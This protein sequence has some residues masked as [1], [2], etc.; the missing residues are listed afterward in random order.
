M[1]LSYESHPLF[2]IG[3]DWFHVTLHPYTVFPM[4]HPS[5][6]S[7]SP[8]THDDGLWILA[9]YSKSWQQNWSEVL[10]RVYFLMILV[11][12]VTIEG[13]QGGNLSKMASI[14]AN[15]SSFFIDLLRFFGKMQHALL[16]PLT[17]CL[18]CFFKFFIERHILQTILTGLLCQVLLDHR[19]KKAS[20]F[21]KLIPNRPSSPSFSRTRHDLI[22]I[23]AINWTNIRHGAK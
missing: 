17:W 3:H 5:P 6:L 10:L 8:L 19:V 9:I 16:P 4:H 15:D 1:A 22:L 2:S 11:F 14:Y 7:R 12:T 13:T 20:M 21:L 23:S 18:W